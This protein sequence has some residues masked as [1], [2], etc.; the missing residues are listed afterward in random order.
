MA[1]FRLPLKTVARFFR[2]IESG[3]MDNPYVSPG[4]ISEPCTS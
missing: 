4:R 1:K 2:A 3:Y